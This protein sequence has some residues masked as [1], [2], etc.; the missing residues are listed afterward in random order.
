MTQDGNAPI[1]RTHVDFTVR[2]PS[3]STSRTPGGQRETHTAP[4]A[5]TMARADRWYR[6]E[7]T[8][9]QSAA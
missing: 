2:P 8:P 3:R 4:G 5:P 9:A 7:A 6:A 1:D